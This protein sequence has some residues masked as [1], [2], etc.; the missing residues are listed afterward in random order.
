[1]L[2]EG[3]KRAKR[4]GLDTVFQ[5]ASARN[6]HKAVEVLACVETAKSRDPASTARYRIVVPLSHGRCS[7]PEQ[8]VVS[9]QRSRRRYPCPTN[10]ESRP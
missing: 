5:E 10:S 4:A 1:M 3:R 2:E 8:E 9:S 6:E 7:W